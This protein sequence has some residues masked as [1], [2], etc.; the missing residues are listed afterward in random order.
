MLWRASQAA[1]RA[2]DRAL[3]GLPLTARQYVVLAL[4]A[5][6]GSESHVELVRLS[7]MD[8]TTLADVTLRLQR[9]GLLERRPG[10][11]DTRRVGLRLTAVGV[12]VLGQAQV[13]VDKVEALIFV[14][15]P[16]SARQDLVGLLACVARLRP[17]PGPLAGLDRG[18]PPTASRAGDAAD[19][20]V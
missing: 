13:I 17:S 9:R 5:A 1:E 19:G 18:G 6:G 10:V 2:L 15:L 8:R 16:A 20:S 14:G 7:G 3:L 11:R 4:L 12:E